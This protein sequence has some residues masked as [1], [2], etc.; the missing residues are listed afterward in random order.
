MCVDWRF[1]DVYLTISEFGSELLFS[2]FFGCDI[3]STV[4]FLVRT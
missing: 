1:K 2:I 4:K 3:G